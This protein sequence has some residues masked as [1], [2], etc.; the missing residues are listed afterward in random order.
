MTSKNQVPGE[1]VSSKMNKGS[2]RIQL[3]LHLVPAAT[4]Q[5]LFPNPF[6]RKLNFTVTNVEATR[7]DNKTDLTLCKISISRSEGI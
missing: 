3:V 6:D 5:I 7:R 1:L 4:R 2:K